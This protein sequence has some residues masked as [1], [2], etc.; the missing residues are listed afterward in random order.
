V[1][2]RVRIFGIRHHGPGSAR[3][4][5]AELAAWQP[6]CVLVEGPPDG[7]SLLPLARHEEMDPPVALLVHVADNPRL[8]AFYPFAE[9]S[10]EWVALR[11]ALSAGVPVRFMDL[12]QAHQLA[13]KDPGEEGPS[14]AD[15]TPAPAPPP[16]EAPALRRDPI[17]LLAAAAG[18]SDG[19][20][21]WEH[22][23]EQRRDGTGV[24]E[25][26]LEAMTALRETV[27]RESPEPDA[28]E[29]ER[30]ARREAW[31]RQTIRAALK[32]RHE[33]IAV[34]CGAW[35]GPALATLPTAKADAELLAGMPKVKVAAT[36]VPWT[37]GRLTMAGGYGAGVESPGWYHHLWH[38]P[39]DVTPRW[40][41]RVARLLR[42]EDLDASSASVIEA[43]RLAE[44]LA[45]LRDRPLPGLPELN[46]AALSVF[47]FGGAAPLRL[48]EEK[49]IVGERL[50]RVPAAAPAVPLQQDLAALQKRLRLPPEA[51][52]RDYDLDLRKPT[53]LE[54]SRL[55]RRLGLLGIPWGRLEHTDGT[56]TFREVWRLQWQPEFAVAVVQAGVWGNTVLD[57]AEAFVRRQA[58]RAPT[59]PDLLSLASGALLADL[60]GAVG[61]VMARVESTAAVTSDLTHLMQML[62][63]VADMIRYPNVRGT[64]RDMLTRVVA[65]VVPRIC[66][67]L[68]EA[69]ASLDDEAADFMLQAMLACG[70][71]LALIRD[72]GHVSAWRETL[73]RL[74]DQPGLH[75]LLAGRCVWLLLD[76]GVFDAEEAARR[77]GLALSQAADPAAAAAWVEGLLRGNGELL[78][79]TDPLW[80]AMDA[81]VTHLPEA[82]FTE[83]LPLLRRTSSTFTAPERRLMGE[84]ARR[85]Q[86]AAPA[87]AAGE[88]DV[89]EARAARVLPVLRAILGP[90]EEAA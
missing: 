53:D 8:A 86:R 20:R 73:G 2:D 34:V 89:D 62:P 13:S 39:D 1:S 26:L 59:L 60:P 63:V 17:G 90:R 65:G 87:A 45:A 55:L 69:C 37:Y 66:V 82:A 52:H 3:S 43:V 32:E 23:V 7:D 46:E 70:R 41:T 77:L 28:A 10:P 84:R 47:C 40:M 58:D 88:G 83:L 44:A 81:W 57:A 36:W 54:R 80:E 79:H 24:F 50:G 64:D 19:E 85:N 75:G 68:P 25:A 61:A 22:A 6:D 42:D 29:A 30:E 9:F 74:A 56:G 67:G 4:L 78:I 27:D 51:A 5:R 21:W 35:H 18:Y 11:H 33:R 38:W 72:D 48:I 14:D 31:M 12:P 15:A 71:G 76:A 16:P 49:L